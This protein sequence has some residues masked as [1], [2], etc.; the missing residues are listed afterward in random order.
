MVTI[1]IQSNDQNFPLGFINESDLAFSDI[2][3][4]KPNP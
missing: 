3:Q 4:Q 1:L 2:F